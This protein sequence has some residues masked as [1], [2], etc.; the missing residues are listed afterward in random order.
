MPTFYVF[1]LFFFFNDTATTE[2]YTLS[3]H[4]ALPISGQA[5]ASRPY[6]TRVPVASGSPSRKPTTTRVGRPTARAS[7]ANAVA[8]CS[9]VPDRAPGSAPSSRNR[10]VSSRA[11]DEPVG[12]P[13][14]WRRSARTAASMATACSNGVLA[15]KETWR[16]YSA[17]RRGSLGV[18]RYGWTVAPAGTAAL[19]TSSARGASRTA[20]MRYA[21]PGRSPSRSASEPDSGS[22]STLDTEVASGAPGDGSHGPSSAATI[23]VASRRTWFRPGGRAVDA[24]APSGR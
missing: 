20:L 15:P 9:A 4:D 1:V 22:T 8:N 17:N 16:A 3:L 7:T 6:T 13:G 10:K 14:S 24:S 18:R 19:A 12:A 23:T 2:I 11:Y 5:W 21:R